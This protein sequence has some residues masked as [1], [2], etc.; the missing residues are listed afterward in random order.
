MRK[1]A[2]ALTLLASCPGIYIHAQVPTATVN[3]LVRDS[4][5]ALIQ[6]AEV[7][8][9]SLK[10]GTVR[11]SLS[12]PDGSYSLSN[13]QPDEYLIAISAPGFGTVQYKDVRL[14][15]GKTTTPDT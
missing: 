8:V 2:L 15:A 5:G 1:F 12:N 13:L 11:I 7:S 10:Q 3:G 9:T 4:Q 6:H 14:E